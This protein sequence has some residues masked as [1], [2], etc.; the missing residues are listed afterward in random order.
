MTYSYTNAYTRTFTRTSA[1]YLAS[2][3]AG[4]LRR[5]SSYYGSPSESQIQDY[6]QELVEMLAQGY[7]ESVEYGF[8]REDRR[9]VTL[10]YEF[11]PDG[12][13]ADSRSGG[14]YAYADITGAP[15]FSFMAYTQKWS[16]LSEAARVAFVAKLPFKRTPGQAPA[17]G[18]GYWATDRSY[19]IDGFGIQR[20]TFRPY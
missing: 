9:V 4:D 6:L 1:Q 5:V 11:H 12:T 16:D 20:K 8:K 10:Y 14:V 19:S 13:L 18:S 2:K 15:W 17:D 3:V 7:V